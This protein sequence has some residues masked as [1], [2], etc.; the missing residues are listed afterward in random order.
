MAKLVVD[1]ASLVS[2]ANAIRTKSNTTADL[3]FPNGFVDAV[4]GIE[5]GSGGNNEEFEMLKTAFALGTAFDRNTI[6]FNSEDYQFKTIPRLDFSKKTSMVYALSSKY[7][8]Y[9]DYYINSSSCLN[10]NSCCANTTNLK[11]MVGIDC[12]S[13]TSIADLLNA[14]GIETVQEPFDLSNVTN[15]NKA[16]QCDKLK[17]VCF[18]EECIKVSITFTSAVLSADSKQSIFDGLATVE[19]AQTLTLHQNAKTLQSQVDSA[20]AKGWTVAGGTVV[21]EE[22]YYG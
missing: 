15:T 11:T 22:E 20:N 16:F 2:V 10:F 14:S 19:T 18:V 4:N 7:I 6:S 8:E 5:S 9:I 13:A 1:E 21:S 17:D 3:E 12:S